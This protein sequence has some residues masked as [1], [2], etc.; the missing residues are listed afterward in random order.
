MLNNIKG[1]IPKNDLLEDLKNVNHELKKW[2]RI[3]LSPSRYLKS[4]IESHLKLYDLFETY[5]DADE[6]LHNL[7]WIINDIKRRKPIED[8]SNTI[9]FND[10]WD[11]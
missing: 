9:Q 11:D 4:L 10:E 7:K 8:L 2:H 1:L 3:P 6:R 5:K